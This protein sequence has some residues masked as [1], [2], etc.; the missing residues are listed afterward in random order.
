MKDSDLIVVEEAADLIRIGKRNV[1]RLIVAG[2]LPSVKHGRRYTRLKRSD[3]LAF[4]E[5]HYGTRGRD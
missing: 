4:I 1:Y 2:E 5:R 3:V